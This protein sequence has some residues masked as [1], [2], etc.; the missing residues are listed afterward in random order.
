MSTISKTLLAVAVGILVGGATYVMA[1]PADKSSP[2]LTPAAATTTTQAPDVKGPC[3]EAEH[4]NDPRCTGSQQPEDQPN[5]D[6]N[7]VDTDQV[8]QNDDGPQHDVG[9]DNPG[10]HHHNSGPGSQNSGPG[11]STAMMARATTWAMTAVAVDP[12][13]ADSM[14][15]AAPASRGRTAPAPA[16]PARTTRDPAC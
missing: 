10:Q 8:G 3:D 15:T 9:D 16:T 1:A 13:T 5:D 2:E 7:Q 14:T 11:S 12:M 4:A 6:R